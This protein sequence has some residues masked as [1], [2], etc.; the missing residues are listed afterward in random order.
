MNTRDFIKLSLE[1]SKGWISGLLADMQDQ[2]TTQP[3]S[4]GGNHPL[5]I[6]GHVV[7]AESF[8]LDECI[9]GKPNRFPELKELCGIGSVPQTD[10]SKYPSMDDMFASFEQVRGDVIALLDTIGE[11]DLDKATAAPTEFA[12]WFGTYGQCFSAM[13]VHPSFH[14]GQVS[15]ARRAAGR[16]PLMM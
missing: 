7:Q 15:D 6:L 16:G 4:N 1:M 9:Q 14:A 5:W 3:T 8:L 12:D 11:D 10:A 13:I 2:P